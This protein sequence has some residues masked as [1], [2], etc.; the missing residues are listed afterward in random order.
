MT[1]FWK[2][3][4]S[5]MVKKNGLIN[6][7]YVIVRRGVQ[8][9][10]WKNTVL[11]KEP[12]PTWNDITQVP[13]KLSDPPKIKFLIYSYLECILQK[14]FKMTGIKLIGRILQIDIYWYQSTNRFI[15]YYLCMHSYKGGLT[16]DLMIR[17]CSRN[18]GHH[19]KLTRK[20]KIFFEKQSLF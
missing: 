13:A 6:V 10:T 19:S 16:I 17:A 11:P 1:Q 3:N 9:P 7:L 8:G 12:I 5:L 4:S 15:N 18:L 14:V 2:H 20:K